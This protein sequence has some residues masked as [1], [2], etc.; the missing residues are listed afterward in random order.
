MKTAAT[1]IRQT[2]PPATGANST[3][4]IPIRGWKWFSVRG[5]AWVI[6]NTTGAISINF[7][8]ISLAQPAGDPNA[9]LYWITPVNG[10]SLSGI[11][12]GVVQQGCAGPQCSIA[13]TGASSFGQG[14]YPDITIDT[15]ANLTLAIAGGDANTKLLY[16]M[17]TIEGERAGPG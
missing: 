9:L 16:L 8:V 6:D 12:S 10:S 15:D 17:C 7:A 3:I 11:N 13:G 14:G 4:T 5:I 1:F 2:G